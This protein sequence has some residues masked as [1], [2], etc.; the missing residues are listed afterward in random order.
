LP[1]ARYASNPAPLTV[2]DAAK[3]VNAPVP[4]TVLPMAGGDAAQAV[5]P[6]PLI[7]DVADSV[8][9]AP[10]FGATLPIGGGLEK[11]AVPAAAWTNAVLASCVVLVP[12]AAV[13]PVIIAW[14]VT[15]ANVGLG[16]VIRRYRPKSRYS[17]VARRGAPD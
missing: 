15:L 8:V 9:N 16:N 4:G 14:T 7:V 6:A 17:K 5:N 12:G 11:T 13:G 10:V 3:V 2:E 1:D